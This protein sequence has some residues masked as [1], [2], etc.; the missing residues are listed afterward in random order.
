MKGLITF[1]LVSLL[2]STLVSSVFA[3]SNGDVSD[4]VNLRGVPSS[5]AETELNDRGYKV[6]DREG[7]ASYWWNEKTKT[8]AAI[9][10]TG[11]SVTDIASIGSGYCGK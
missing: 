4:I 11:G 10:M 5:E 1:S 9:V 8:C 3:Q 7:Q 6:A 2:L